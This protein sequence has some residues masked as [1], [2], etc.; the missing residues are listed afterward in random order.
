MRKIHTLARSTAVAGVSLLLVVGASFAHDSTV[1]G[2]PTGGTQTVV[3]IDDDQGELDAPDAVDTEIDTDADDQIEDQAGQTDDGDQAQVK[4]EKAVPAAATVKP[5]KAKPAHVAKPK[6][7]KSATVATQDEANDANDS[8]QEDANDNED[9][10]V[11]DVND[12]D[13]ENHDSGDANDSGDVNGDAN[14]GGGGD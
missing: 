2:A 3:G 6:T 13:V 4:A 8:D 12:T 5:A 1:A 11:D 7:L 9:A 10:E 14:Q